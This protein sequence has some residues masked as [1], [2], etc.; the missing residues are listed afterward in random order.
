MLNI[1]C[2]CFL[3]TSI[4]IF[5]SILICMDE[6]EIPF[7]QM[8]NLCNEKIETDIIFSDKNNIIGIN[9]KKI[10]SEIPLKID[11]KLSVYSILNT[12][13]KSLN[14]K[15]LLKFKTINADEIY[16]LC[17]KNHN[18]FFSKTQIG[19]NFFYKIF[20]INAHKDKDCIYTLEELTTNTFPT[21]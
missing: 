19:G 4:V 1:K 9:Y 6:I 13:E 11:N 5:N 3:F 21:I 18:P 12:K 2:I 10:N 7:D 16:I 8:F 14:D 17:D 15:S 20:F